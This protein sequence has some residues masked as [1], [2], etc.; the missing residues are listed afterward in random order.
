MRNL[1][2]R[3]MHVLL[4]LSK[5]YNYA[6]IAEQIGISNEAVHTHAFNLRMRTHINIHDMEACKKALGELKYIRAQDKPT[7]AQMQVL[8]RVAKGQSHASIAKELKLSIGTVMNA[9]SLGMKRLNSG[10]RWSSSGPNFRCRE[11]LHAA[12]LAIQTGELKEITD[13]MAD[14]AF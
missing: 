12:L 8:Q 2:P 3:Q 11:Q 13:P 7:P 1:T 10:G 4:L 6:A 5:G 14:P 9:A